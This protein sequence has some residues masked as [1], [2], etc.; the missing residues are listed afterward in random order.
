MKIF[1]GCSNLEDADSIYLESARESG[2]ISAK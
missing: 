1:V 2:K